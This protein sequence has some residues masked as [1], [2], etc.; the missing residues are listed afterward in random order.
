MIMYSKFDTAEGYWATTT[1]WRILSVRSTTSISA[2]WF[3]CGHSSGLGLL[4]VL[5]TTGNVHELKEDWSRGLKR[6][7]ARS[8]N[9]K[10]GSENQCAGRIVD[11]EY[12]QRSKTNRGCE[13]RASRWVGLH[14]L[15]QVS[16]RYTNCEVPCRCFAVEIRCSSSVSSLYSLLHLQDLRMI[17]WGATGSDSCNALLSNIQ[18][19][20]YSVA[21]THDRFMIVIFMDWCYYTSCREH[22]ASA[23]VVGLSFTPLP[24]P[25]RV[26]REVQFWWKFMTPLPR[27]DLV[28]PL[29][30]PPCADHRLISYLHWIS[31][32]FK[33]FIFVPFNNVIFFLPGATSTVSDCFK[34]RMLLSHCLIEWFVIKALIK[35][36]RM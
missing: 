2:A 10:D 30:P 3:L 12:E 18:V 27:P 11:S 8:G 32:F 17:I 19:S 1:T 9:K 31:K 36:S 29:P 5:C 22:I 35:A 16:L 23:L 14:P 4:H 6:M 28:R 34:E 25:P 20:K 7:E 33:I 15:L 26:K 13:L 24:P 21:C